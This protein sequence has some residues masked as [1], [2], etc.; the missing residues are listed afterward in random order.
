M[1]IVTT[2]DLVDIVYDMDD[3]IVHTDPLDPGARRRLVERLASTVGREPVSSY[4]SEEVTTA[5]DDSTLKGAA[6]LMLKNQVHHLPI[7]NENDELVGMLSSM[8]ILAEI[9]DEE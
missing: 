4:M 8:D 6:R 5:R 3:D 7:V 1:G 2:T 9:A